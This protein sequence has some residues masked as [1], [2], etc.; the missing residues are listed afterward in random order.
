LLN[1]YVSKLPS[2]TYTADKPAG[3]LSKEWADKL[4]LSTDVIIGIGAM[5]AH[6][7][8][9]GGQIEPYYLS[10]VMGTS[11]CDML[12]APVEDMEG[13]FVQGICG[14]VNGSVIPNM[15]GMEAGQ[16]AFG[17][18]YAWFKNLIVWPLENIA[19]GIID[20]K[21]IKSITDKIIPE[22]NRQ[23]AATPLHEHDEISIDWFNGRRTPD[24]NAYL[25]SA[26]TGLDLGSD[27]VKIFRSLAEATCFGA[28]AIVEC[29]I[30]QKISVR[31]LIGIGGVAKKSPFIM[32]MMADVMN[33]PIRINRSEQTCALGAA[34][35]AATVAGIYSKVE[36]AMESM[37]QGFDMEYFPDK[38]KVELYQ[39]RYKKYFELGNYIE[40][41]DASSVKKK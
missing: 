21:M 13:K 7:G 8:A 29:F 40:N 6:M 5:D 41:N 32:Q 3:N 11:T 24:A 36:D 35:F 17:D 14:L 22:L 1:G 34:M 28:K 18:V 26:I 19:H 31:G 23:A 25:K 12:V 9:V 10:K 38:N 30:N 16:S 39:H 15:I 4:G 37:G 20:E 33:M 2:T 27:A